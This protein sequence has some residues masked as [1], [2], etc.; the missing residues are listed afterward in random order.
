MLRALLGLRQGNVLA[1]VAAFAV[2]GRLLQNEGLVVGRERRRWLQSTATA[3]KGAT[4]FVAAWW[5]CFCRTTEG[6]GQ[7]DH[8]QLRRRLR[9]LAAPVVT[10]R[11][12]ALAVEKKAASVVS[13]REVAMLEMGNRVLCFYR[14]TAGAAGDAGNG[15]AAV[16]V[17]S[18]SSGSGGEGGVGGV[19][20]GNKGNR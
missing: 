3:A 11:S 20:V 15:G 14:T 9:W 6:V 5:F 7:K 4:G 10:G 1:A 2:G 16:I 18:R 13:G 8:K 17:R 12:A 19:T